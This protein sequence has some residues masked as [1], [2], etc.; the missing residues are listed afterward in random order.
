MS[1][2]RDRNVLDLTCVEDNKFILII[3]DDM[4]WNFGIRQYHCKLLQDKINDYIGFILSG[5]AEEMRPGLRCVIRILAQYSFSQYCIDYLNRVRDYISSKDNFCDIEWVHDDKDGSVFNDG[6]SDDFVFDEEKIYPRL[7]KNWAK[8]PSKEVSLMATN[9]MQGNYKDMPMFR[10]FDSF[11]ICLI[12][13][14]GSAFSYI[15]YDMLPEGTDVEKLRDKAF[16]NLTRDIKF[17]Y[18]ESMNYKGVYGILCGGDFEAETLCCDG[19]WY[20][21]AEKFGDDIMISIP[22]KDMVLFTVAG[23]RKLRDSLIKFG[24]EVFERNRT[25]SPHLL[26]C[27]DIFH[28]SRKDGKITIEKKLT[29]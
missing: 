22:T 15:D 18:E 24:R 16:E 19:V 27:K 6:F 25:E 5:Q 1:T 11:I 8:D 10:V 12:Q 3:I 13:D 7:R 2:L 21:M 28:Y 29:L 17:R 23:D 26:F 9:S 20:E 14:T 4:E